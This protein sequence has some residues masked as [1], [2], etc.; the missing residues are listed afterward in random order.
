LV[1]EEERGGEGRG[2]EEEEE[3]EKEKEKEEKRGE[4]EGE[5]EEERR[6]EKR[7]EEKRREEKRREEKRREEKRRKKDFLEY[8]ENQ[9]TTY[10]NLWDTMKAVLKGKQKSECCQKEIAESMHYQLN[11]TPESSRTKRSKYTQK[12]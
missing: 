1:K 7:R 2:G 10:P 12:E 4:G 3:K 8:N 9:G 5:R 11:S 6:E